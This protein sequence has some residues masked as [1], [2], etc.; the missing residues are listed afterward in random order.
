MMV[1]VDVPDVVILLLD[2][3]SDDPAAGVLGEAVAVNPTAPV[4]PPL[5]V[6][7]IVDVAELPTWMLNVVG[8]AEIAK[9][10]DPAA[11]TVT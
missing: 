3:V 2:S 9:S 5:A 8:F 7:V 1:S 4:N 10:A 6:I 11:V